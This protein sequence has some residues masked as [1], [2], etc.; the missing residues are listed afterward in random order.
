[1][2]F[3]G[4]VGTLTV[5]A[6]QATPVFLDRAAI[7][8]VAAGHVASADAELVVFGEAGIVSAEL[9]LSRIAAGR[10]MFDPT[11]HYSRP[12]VLSL[13]EPANDVAR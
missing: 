9:D 1:V 2:S 5:A 4:V 10:R 7:V 13:R 8:A 3:D 12:D 11:G 6:V